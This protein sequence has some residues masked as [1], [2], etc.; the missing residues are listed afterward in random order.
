MYLQREKMAN[1]KRISLAETVTKKPSQSNNSLAVSILNDVPQK[2]N[3][4]TGISILDRT[5]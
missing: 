5:L 4:T 3:R 2:Q 1:G